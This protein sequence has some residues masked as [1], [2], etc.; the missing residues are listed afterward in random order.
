MYCVNNKED[1]AAFR[2]SVVDRQS[3]YVIIQDLRSSNNIRIDY[4]KKREFR[5]SAGAFSGIYLRTTHP[6]LYSH[7]FSFSNI[8]ITSS[9]ENPT[10]VAASINAEIAESTQGWR[11]VKDY[12][13]TGY[14]VD[15][16]LREG[17]GQLYEGPFNIAENIKRLLESNGIG[18][19]STAT[20]KLNG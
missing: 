14:G 11:S 10:A 6:L 18:Y 19:S 16:I 15:N 17:S 1:E 7:E 3:T 9:S 12:C 4:I 2:G 5:I 20:G 8:Y 13:N